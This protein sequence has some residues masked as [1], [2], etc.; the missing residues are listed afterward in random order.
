[1]RSPQGGAL[2]ALPLKDFRLGI[3]EAIDIW[4]DAVATANACD[5]AQVAREVLRDWAKRK[6]REHTVATRRFAAN[7]MQPELFGDDTEDDGVSRS[8]KK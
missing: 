2:M 4:L 7:G 3:T 5:K 6:H 1:V 8:A